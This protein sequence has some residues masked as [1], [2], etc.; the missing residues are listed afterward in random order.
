MNMN[1]MTQPPVAR[2]PERRRWLAMA[3]LFAAS[4]VNMLDIGI[5]N[6]ALPSI[7]RSLLANERQI[8][9]IVEIYILV[10]ALGLLPLGRLGDIIGRKTVFV[11][12]VAVFTAASAWCGAASSA[13][14]L[15]LARGVQGLGAAMMSPQVVAIAATMFEPRERGRVFPLFGLVA[16]LA[17]IMGPLASGVLIQADPL[18]LGWRS[19]F[20]VNVPFG[21]A[22]LIATLAWVPRCPPHPD[23]END[24]GGIGLAAAAIFC[25]VLPL[26]EGRSH[27]WPIWSFVV[28]T[29]FVPLLAAFLFWERR[30]SDKGGSALLPIGLMTSWDYLVGVGAIMVFFSALQGFFLVFALLLQQGFG[31]SPLDA[32]LVTAPFPVGA[33]V[34]TTISTRF[35]SLRWK[36]IGGSALLILSVVA[37]WLLIRNATDDGLAQG[38]LVASLFVGGVG[39]SLC[40]ASLFQTVMRTVPLKD[41]GAGS[42]AMQVMQ[43]IGG[44]VGIALVSMIYF[45]GLVPDSAGG[46]PDAAAFKGAF[47]NTLGYQIAAY[48]LVLGSALL[49]RFEPPAQQV[50]VPSRAGA[51]ERA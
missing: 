44:A 19:V 2:S 22:T 40:L 41:A 12:G 46:A 27:G 8:E 36:I 34:A 6:V 45:G 48:L 28:M 18:Q 16:G 29:A 43:Q 20:F 32:G 31:F 42:G 33:L 7:Q 4:F 15:I 39:N 24:W 11:I 51:G 38:G 50:G 47:S 10:Y 25:L 26:I 5:I 13:G 1:V 35:D 30:Q 23:L 37:L 3:V 9:W 49:L 17:A 21:A 14:M